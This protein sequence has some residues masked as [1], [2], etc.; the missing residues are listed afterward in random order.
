MSPR[1]RSLGHRIRRYDAPRRPH[2]AGGA[3]GGG[4][5]RFR[6]VAGPGGVAAHHPNRGSR[7]RQCVPPAQDRWLMGPSIAPP[8]IA[9]MGR[10]LR[11]KQTTSE[12]LTRAALDQVAAQDGAVHA[13]ITVT[14]ERALADARRADARLCRRAGCGGDAGRPVWAERHLRH[15][16]DPHD[17]PLQA[18]GGQCARRG[19]GRRGQACGGGRRADRQAGHA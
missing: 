1:A 11:A 2:R 6:R 18:A 16:G 13:F 3:P 4:A 8:S 10:Q 9:S 19:F 14:A 12:A 17:L 5:G 15:G 7:A